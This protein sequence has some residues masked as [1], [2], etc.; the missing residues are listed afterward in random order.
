MALDD[1]G[2][3][4][5]YLTKLR[6]KIREDSDI[7][8]E[9]TEMLHDFAL[10]YNAEL[11]SVGNVDQYNP[12]AQEFLEAWEALRQDFDVWVGQISFA[13]VLELQAMWNNREIWPRR[14]ARLPSIAPPRVDEE[15]EPTPEMPP[16]MPGMPAPP[17]KGVPKGAG[18]GSA[19]TPSWV[20]QA[21]WNFSE[22]GRMNPAP[23]AAPPRAPS[24]PPAPTPTR[25]RDQNVYRLRVEGDG[26]YPYRDRHYHTR[27]ATAASAA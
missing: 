4:N 22:H 8:R 25:Y 18:K 17:A 12:R 13:D 6:V 24:E 26:R 5:Q 11:Q 15:Q 21:S 20:G 27:V 7:M 19:R 14:L 9:L 2:M 3:K 10:S 1:D 16:I 23:P